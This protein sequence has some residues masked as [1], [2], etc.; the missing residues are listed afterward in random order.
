MLLHEE[1]NSNYGS[2]QAEE[3]G[4]TGKHPDHDVRP[5]AFLNGGGVLASKVRL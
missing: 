4:K 1:V 3:G 5:R 2:R